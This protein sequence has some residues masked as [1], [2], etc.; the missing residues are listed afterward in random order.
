MDTGTLAG[1][2]RLLLEHRETP[3][4]LVR[5]ALD[6]AKASTGVFICLMEKTA[7][8]E[9]ADA[10][11]RRAGGAAL[12]DFDGIP[13][14]VKDLFDVMGSVTTA[15]SRTRL[16]VPTALRDSAIVARLR[17]LGM[18]PIGKTN[19]SEFAFSGLGLNPHFGTPTASG[20]EDRA[21]GGSS[22]G[23]AIAVQRG[24]VPVALGT[25]TAGS[26][27]IPAAFNGLVGFRPSRGR[28]EMRGVYPLAASFD[29]AGPITRSIEDCVAMDAMMRDGSPSNVAPPRH[30]IME[31]GLLDD[32]DVEPAVRQNLLTFADMLRSG[33]AIV[34]QRAIP[35]IGR[36]R[37]AISELG[38]PGGVEAAAFH[39]NLLASKDRALVDPRVVVRL[40]MAATTPP[41]NM[42]AMRRIRTELIDTLRR[43]LDGAVMIQPTVPHV[44][45][46]LSSLASD[47]DLF[48]RV[49]L[50]TLWMTMIGSFLDMP[51]LAV[52]SGTDPQGL[53]TSVLLTGASGSDDVV[54]AAG[55]L[56]ARSHG[57]DSFS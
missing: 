1:Q 18:I 17:K 54:L 30:L 19:L 28:Y 10:T 21:P 53:P 6:K 56:A 34:E 32:P 12:S 29:T 14:A 33:G 39:R 37:A 26:V 50:K 16:A 15:G 52:P 22:S 40:D 13:F 43:E 4:M 2:A 27:R 44:A 42:D 38:W 48:A 20:H 51:G 23:S 41:G 24:I 47:D 9:A 46:L 55:L 31:Q 45:P 57:T 7:L 36:A 25:D 35:S 11:R 8:A 5:A 3:D 49:N